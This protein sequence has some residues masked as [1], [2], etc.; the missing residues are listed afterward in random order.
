M[1]VGFATYA[2]VHAVVPSLNQTLLGHLKKRAPPHSVVYD[3]EYSYDFSLATRDSGDI[4]LRVDYSDSHDY[5]TQ[6]VTADH[7]K[8]EIQP[9]FWSALQGVWKNGKL[10]RFHS[11]PDTLPLQVY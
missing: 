2:V 4:Y 10:R 8:R 1:H 9:R 5:Y 6:I 3:L 7:Q 11:S